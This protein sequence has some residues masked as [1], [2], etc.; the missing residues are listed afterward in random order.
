LCAVEFAASAVIT[1]IGIKYHRPSLLGIPAKDIGR[2]FVVTGL[3]SVAAF[4][5]DYRP[6]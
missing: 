3:A 4:I 5:I 6:V 2:A 1:F